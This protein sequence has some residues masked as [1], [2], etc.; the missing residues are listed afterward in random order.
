MSTPFFSLEQIMDVSRFS[1]QRALCLAIGL[2]LAGAAPSVLAQ[3][4][5]PS[6]NATINLIRLMVKKG[7]ITQADA[8]G[9]IAEANAEATQ[10]QKAQASQSSLAAANDGAQPGDVRVP[11][12][13]QSVRN[14][15]REQVKQEV[16]AQARSEHWAQPD[17]LPAWLDRIAWSGDIRVRD[18]GRYFSRGNSPYFIDYAALNRGG[19]FDVNQI[20]RGVNPPIANSQQNRP[21]ILSIQAHLGVDVKLGDTIAAGIRIGSGNDNNPVSTTQALGGGLSKKNLWLDRAWL[22]WQPVEWGALTAGRFANPF[23]VTDLIYSPELNF[24]GIVGQG[25]WKLASDIDG[26]VNAGAFPLQYA[27]NDTPSQAF[28]YQKNRS[29]QKWLSA[30]QLGAHWQIDEDMRW[31]AALAYY[32]YDKMR[33]RLSEPC[34]IYTGIN[35]CSTD[36]DAPQYMQKG[37]SV[38]LLR[39]IVPDPSSPGNYAQ[40]QLVGLAYDYHL[41]NLTTQFDFAMGS[42]PVRVQADYVRNLAYHA[43]DAFQRYPDGLG[44]PV[45]NYQASSSPSESGPYKSGP[46]GWLVRGILGNRSPMKA[47]DWNLAFGYKYLQP[48]AVLDGLTDPN[49]HLGGTNA[50]GFIVSADYGIAERT[51]LTA[52]Y[53]NAKQVFGPPLSIDVVQLEIN[54][55]F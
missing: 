37:N 31:S 11:Y 12:V 21:N 29:D 4:A 41:L 35:F 52:R 26:F 43:K 27:G 17:A 25:H 54:S 8:D 49:F 6:P 5:A 19:P 16:I 47:H 1:K 14:E 45:N 33:G 23:F 15:I 42:T 51:W 46:V 55:K 18:E 32:Y 36:D 34:P 3:N 22:R 38:F 20:G 30:V 44:Q 48:D 2:L 39:N 9:L 50:K 10:A 13:P 24:D 28:G 40:P 7:L 53:F